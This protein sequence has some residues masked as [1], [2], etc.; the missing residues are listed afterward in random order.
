MLGC[1][2]LLI[3]FFLLLH[4]L[5]ESLV[6]YKPIFWLETIAFIAFDFS[7][8]VKGEF[9]WK[10]IAVL[11]DICKL[12]NICQYLTSQNSINGKSIWL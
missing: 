2:I 1:I 7:W 10:D 9:L 5:Y 11:N 12:N 4:S 8:L 3:V 6:I